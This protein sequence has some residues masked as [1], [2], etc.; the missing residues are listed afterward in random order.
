MTERVAKDAYYI[1]ERDLDRHIE[2]EKTGPV[3]VV[4]DYRIEREGNP[5]GDVAVLTV[6]DIA[7]GSV[8]LSAKCTERYSEAL[9]EHRFDIDNITIDP[10]YSQS[11]G[12]V[13]MDPMEKALLVADSKLQELGASQL[14]SGD[15][16]YM[17]ETGDVNR[18]LVF[19]TPALVGVPS[20]NYHFIAQQFEDGGITGSPY[21]QSP[22][23]LKAIDQQFNELVEGVRQRLDENE[24]TP[25]EPQAYQRSS[26]S[27]SRSDLSDLLG[28]EVVEGVNPALMI[29]HPAFQTLIVGNAALDVAAL[30]QRPADRTADGLPSIL[31]Q[32]E[33]LEK[34]TNFLQ[35]KGYEIEHQP[36]PLQT[37][38]T[39]PEMESAA[40]TPDKPPTPKPVPKTQSTQAQGATMSTAVEAKPVAKEEVQP[41]L[42]S[43]MM[44]RRSQDVLRGICGVEGR[45][46][47][48]EPRKPGEAFKALV[49]DAYGVENFLKAN[50]V[51]HIGSADYVVNRAALELGLSPEFKEQ[52]LADIN[53]EECVPRVVLATQKE[54][55]ELATD[56][57][58]KKV[59]QL[60]PSA[61]EAAAP[62][63]V[64][65]RLV[66]Q[67]FSLEASHSKVLES[68]GITLKPREVEQTQEAPKRAYTPHYE[69]A[70]EGEKTDR[71]IAFRDTLTVS[72]LREF[73]NALEVMG[74][75]QDAKNYAQDFA[76][77][78]AKSGYRM[79]DGGISAGMVERL[80]K[81]QD[82]M[83][84]VVPAYRT[85]VRESF[86][87]V[88]GDKG[89]VDAPK[90][91]V[92]IA[93]KDGTFTVKDRETKHLQLLV[94][95]GEVL[96]NRVP[97][98]VV[99]KV[100]VM[101]DLSRQ[102]QQ[103]A[104]V[105]KPQPVKAG[106]GRD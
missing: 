59:S 34:V 9:E 15:L 94:K 55:G 28:M 13:L 37:V 61:Y 58:W 22:N 51:K 26:A 68:L 71:A 21:Y 77:K 99:G 74:A 6:T 52:I 63:E 67:S 4:G 60:S 80:D 32:N 48:A 35:Q 30:E 75:N 3:S 103:Q 2:L 57:V 104:A 100:E 98:V 85:T 70:P 10:A 43:E 29:E 93:G 33:H 95:D 105:T 19:A 42:I 5:Y 25:Q 102:Q 86:E 11:L 56:N 54:M 84:A 64:K 14:R 24:I 89:K 49:T 97:P 106:S 40:T 16:L 88:L 18:T 76:D 62:A 90:L 20:E 45:G 66:E 83:E 46:A 79:N 44:S 92:E 53:R 8:V 12:L 69:V 72:Q 73:Q 91:G 31:I 36:L 82:Q 81:L 23:V 96:I 17:R 27:E 65:D 38:V 101:A 87:Q 41:I 1:Y 78:F 7:T 50:D 47:Q 39:A